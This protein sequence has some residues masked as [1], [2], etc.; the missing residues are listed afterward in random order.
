METDLFII[1]IIISSII[2]VGCIIAYYFNN[3]NKDMDGDKNDND[4]NNT[5]SE[6]IPPGGTPKTIIKDDV[7][8]NSEFTEKLEYNEDTLSLISY[9]TSEGT[10]VEQTEQTSCKSSS[11]INMC[12]KAKKQWLEHLDRHQQEKNDSMGEKLTRRALEQIYGKKFP[13]VRPAWLTNPST[14]CRLELDGYC[15]ELKMAF[16]YHGIQHREWPNG[17]F[18]TKQEFYNQVA[19]D[20]YKT[21]KCEQQGIYLIII[22]YTIPHSEIFEAVKKLTP[23][24]RMKKIKNK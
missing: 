1:M 20:Q 19:R 22:D 11:M 5:Q 15:E 4:T 18:K 6:Y 2:I 13:K 23:E 9:G 14:G 17:F 16:E 3:D 10:D 24:Y 12:N 8:I 21:E 7:N